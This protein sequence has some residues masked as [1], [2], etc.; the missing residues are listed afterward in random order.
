MQQLVLTFDDHEPITS[1]SDLQVLFQKLNR[2]YWKG[3]LPEFRCEWSDRMITTWGSCYRGKKLIRI[4]S[5]FKKR[6]VPELSALLCHEMIHIRYGGH[7]SKFKRELKRIGLEGDVQRLFPHLNKM[8]LALRRKH[9][10]VYECSACRMQIRR[11]R[12]I[13]GYC[14][15]CWKRGVHS[16]FRVKARLV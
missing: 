10:Y 5:F 6:P 16:R 1:A 2:T 7:G 15:A 4:S 14:V 12:K 13:R 11:R 8:T 3:E 9:R